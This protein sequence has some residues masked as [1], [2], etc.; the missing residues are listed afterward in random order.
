[1]NKKEF[2]LSEDQENIINNYSKGFASV[3]AT[4]GAGKTT[5]I[6]LLIKKLIVEDK[7]PPQSILILTLTESAAKEFKERTLALFKE[8]KLFY[9]SLPEFSTIH[10][11]CHRNLSRYYK[12]YET[13]KL[14]PDTQRNEQIEKLLLDRGFNLEEVDEQGRVEINYL[15]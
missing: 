11:F 9:K 15:D 12:D 7:I 6:T 5:I 10:S 4:P 1:M 2:K 3:L 13:L 8:E 14:L